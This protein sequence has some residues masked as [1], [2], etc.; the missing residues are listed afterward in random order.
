MPL[1]RFIREVRAI[2]ILHAVSA[3]FSNG[4]VPVAALFLFLA[5]LSGDPFLDHSVLHLLLVVFL[6]VPISL[7]SGIRDW[8]SKFH[9]RRAPIFTRKIVLSLVLFLLC[10]AALGIRLGQPEVIRQP[11]ML[12]WIYATCLVLMCGVVFLLGHY[13]ASLAAQLRTPP[14]SDSK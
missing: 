10:G 1:L 14:H 3:H 7:V 8:R 11:G 4:L 2:F 5:L 6:A 13:G 12:T 9:G